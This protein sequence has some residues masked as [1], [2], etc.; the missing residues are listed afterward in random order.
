VALPIAHGLLG[1]AV[2]APWLPRQQLRRNLTPLLVAAGLGICPDL[3]YVFYRVLDWGESWHRSFSHSVVFALVLGIV[4]AYVVGPLTTR[5]FV[6]YTLAIFSHPILDALISEFPSGVE[7]LWPFSEHRFG[8]SVIDYPHIFGQSRETA[9]IVSRIL[10]ISLVEFLFFAPVL[11]VS[12]WL[13]NRTRLL[14]KN[15]LTGKRS[16]VS[17]ENL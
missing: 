17:S 6:L 3:D 2:A 13:S 14:A 16:K 8:F 12:L 11:I 15:V 7:L 10:L 1:A 9:A 4:T 5:F